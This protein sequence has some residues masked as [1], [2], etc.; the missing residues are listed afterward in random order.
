MRRALL[1]VVAAAVLVL[2]APTRAQPPGA[3]RIHFMDV[4]QGDGAILIAPDGETV[5]V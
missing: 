5:G 1:F 3:L 4:S 2:Y